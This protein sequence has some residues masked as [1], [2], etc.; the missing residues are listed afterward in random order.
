[1]ATYRSIAGSE[2][3]AN[4]PVT[5]TLME[6]LADNPT[7]IA[8]GAT[9]APVVNAGW[10]PYDNIIMGDGN[11]G[12]FYDHSVDGNVS[13]VETPTF[14]DGYEYMVV[15]T[16]LSPTASAQ[17]LEIQLHEETDNAYNLTITIGG[18]GIQLNEK[19]YSRVYTELPRLAREVHML[20]ADTVHTVSSTN[21]AGSNNVQGSD[22]GSSQK[23]DKIRIR[24]TTADIDGGKMYLF[25]R[26][27][28]LT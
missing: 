1:M 3:D 14:V 18:G 20:R 21:F 10:H 15:I 23:A 9:D 17:S 16:E 4:S 13:S 8:E 2:T 11:D 27:D 5:Q 19:L 12:V 26:R 25:R 28:H 7:A 6:A 24:W 22:F